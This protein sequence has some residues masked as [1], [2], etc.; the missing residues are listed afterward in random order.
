MVVTDYEGLGTPGVHTYTVGPSA[1]R[2]MLAA[3]RA[4]SRLPETG[5]S[6]NTPVGIMGYSQGGQ[7]GS[8]AAEL[9]GSYARSCRSRARRRAASRP[10][11]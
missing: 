7:A 2:A 6:A 9:Q 8:R 4:A 1:S 5:L 3:A 11:C 10:T